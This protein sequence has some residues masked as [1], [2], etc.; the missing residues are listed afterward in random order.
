[1]FKKGEITESPNGEKM[2]VNED[3]TAY[4][5]TDAVITIWDSFEG[6]TVE[7]VTEDI[8]V[9]INRRPDELIESVSKMASML[10]Q[11]DLLIS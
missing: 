1:M 2:L 10:E 8:A 5:A 6:N 9:A 11:A 7:E 3:G 4:T